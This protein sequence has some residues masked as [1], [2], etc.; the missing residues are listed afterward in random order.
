MR[1]GLRRV[2]VEADETE[3]KYGEGG[4]KG[5]EG[6]FTFTSWSRR[7]VRRLMIFGRSK[8]ERSERLIVE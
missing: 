1:T 6:T 8:V 5:D 7:T 4:G 2:D 3:E